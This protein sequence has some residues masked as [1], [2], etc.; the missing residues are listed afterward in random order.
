MTTRA[1]LFD[2]DG[3]LVD[4]NYLHVEAYAHAFADFDLAVDAWRIHRGIGMDG[5]KLMQSLLGDRADE[6]A[7]RVKDRNA[8]HYRSLAPRLRAFDGARELLRV[9]AERDVTVVLA[10]SA[11]ENELE[12]LRGVLDVEDALTAV[13]SDGDVETA[14]PAPD[15]VHVALERAKTDAA[16]AVFVGDSVWDMEAAT[17]VGVTAIGVLSGGVSAREL[18]DAGATAVYADVAELLERIDESPL[19][20]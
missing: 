7:D 6:W 16:D 2:I 14:K 9:L 10:T 3:T 15:I 4:S 5:S 12:L 17:S 19:Q 1:V 8:E 11:P 20:G 18:L 13:T